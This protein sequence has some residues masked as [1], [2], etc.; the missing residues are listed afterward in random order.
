MGRL[1]WLACVGVLIGAGPEPAA[2]VWPVAA[3]VDFAREIRPIFNERC[4]ACHGGVKQAGGLSFLMHDR[5]LKPTKSGAVPVVPG[6]P[7]A[8]EVVFRVEAEDDE[9]RMPP[10]EHGPR[11]SQ[12]EVN[13]LRE[14]IAQGAE[15]TE[16][17]AYIPPGPQT[18]P[19]VGDPTWCRLST[20]AFVLARL[21][22]EGIGPSPPADRLAWLRRISFDLIGLP[23]TTEEARAFLSDSR[24]Y[25]YERTVDRLLASPRFGERW[26]SV[27]LDLARYADTQGYERDYG[28]TAWPYRDWLIRALND[29]MP[30]DEFTIRQLAGD[31][32]PDATVDDRVATAFHR[33]TPTNIEDGTDDEEFRTAAVI[34]RVNTTWQVWQGVTFGCTQ[35]HSHPYDPFDHEEYYRF[36]AL[37]NTTRDVDVPQDFPLLR[38]PVDPAD[39]SKAGRLDRRIT[40][41]RQEVNRR[42][43]K[44]AA[45]A[46]QWAPLSPIEATST[47]SAQLEV[48][49]I[50]GVPEL[51]AE[52]TISAGSRFTIESP[53]PEGI[54]KL[55][56]LRIEVLPDD[57]EA[58]RSS[59]ELGFVLS[60]LKAWVVPP[61]GSGEAEG[62]VEV[63]FVAAFDDDPQSFFRAEDSLDDDDQGW[64][65]Y[66]LM[67]RPRMAVFVTER[68]VVLASGSTLK[69]EL[70]HKMV[71]TGFHPLVIRR[72]RLSVSES[73]AWT[74][75]ITSREDTSSR[76]ELA[77]LEK[78]RVTIRSV[79][80]PVMSEQ[81]TGDRRIT[82]LFVRGNW[83]DKG[84]EVTPGVPK[85]FAS[86][87]S[88]RPANRLELARWLVS[89]ENSLTAR[90]TVNRVWEQLFGTGLVETLED[91]GSSGM[92]PSHPELLDF[93]AIRL[94]DELGWSL[95]GLLRELVLSATYRQDARHRPD[96]AQRDP[97]NRLLARGP[98]VRLSAEMVRDQALAASGLLS[99]KLHGPPV[100]PPQPEGIWR[101]VYNPMTWET[102]P[103]EDRYRRA[104]YTFWKRTSGYPSFL[105]FDAPSR[106]VCTARRVRT[107]TP[108]Q[109]LVTMNDPVYIECAAALAK[110]VQSEGSA[111]PALWIA[112]AYE[113]AAGRLP[114][115]ETG[116]DLLR[117]YDDSLARYRGSEELAAKL[118]GSPEQAAMTV[119]ANAILNLDA[120]LSK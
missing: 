74:E 45:D 53:L 50:D 79:Q 21:D 46:G 80:L 102:S 88:S 10:A 24:P 87:T 44:V 56:A 23:T 63:K 112:R 42:G 72:A 8:S 2:A 75:L 67:F 105:T 101:S 99:G 60:R 97:G 16:H 55:N 19:A 1:H 106:E 113:R 15:W 3:R 5:V 22:R 33:N 82:R 76:R 4:V 117:L 116:D 6:D 31:M 9:I 78:E 107:N 48:K 38:V 26:A 91:F 11:L 86:T 52:G 94:R 81:A 30:F 90:V 51:R 36:L 95:K 120:V 83:L 62:A 92:K 18:L 17:W 65:A 111:T 85:L 69:L 7:D 34:D 49:V 29:D 104:V 89:E 84:P 118:A 14:W 70:T 20:D 28:R 59:A 93:L 110:G 68:P 103:G 13:L 96:L 12:R 27:W 71:A 58:A 37:F 73:D 41:L 47:G 115:P 98:R 66:A 114:S 109:A 39:G 35:C 54:S 57:V 119:V 32:L 108:L 64:G 77:E 40:E 25:A 61:G 43:L 100:K